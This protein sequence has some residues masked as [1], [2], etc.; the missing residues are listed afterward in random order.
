[1]AWSSLNLTVNAPAQ[2]KFNFGSKWSSK[3]GIDDVKESI[4]VLLMS[5]LAQLNKRIANPPKLT[6]STGPARSCSLF[7]SI[8]C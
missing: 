6:P 3:N 8:F 4:L 7:D 5:V 2:F 1:M